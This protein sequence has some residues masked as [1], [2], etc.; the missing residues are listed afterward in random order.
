MKCEVCGHKIPL[1]SKECLNCGMKLDKEMI[2]S[3]EEYSRKPRK[4]KKCYTALIVGTI[5]GVFIAL[6]V[7]ILAILW[8]F[9]VSNNEFNDILADDADDYYGTIALIQSY[10]DDIL[11][12]V[13]DIGFDDISFNETVN[14]D[15]DGYEAVLEVYCYDDEMLYLIKVSVEEGY[16]NEYYLNIYQEYEDEIPE[17]FPA[18]YVDKFS[19]LL[20]HDHLYDRLVEIRNT[21][22][23]ND[24]EYEGYYIEMY[25]SSESF[26][27]DSYI[28]YYIYKM[29]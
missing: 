2:A 23:D 29:D 5:V 12:C 19:E 7:V 13:E 28:D 6:T 10:E 26:F 11:E 22:L 24:Y 3:V 27:S 4:K 8:L 1:G 25:E 15:E 9:N 21:S 16:C 18:V 17:E 14:G 20:G